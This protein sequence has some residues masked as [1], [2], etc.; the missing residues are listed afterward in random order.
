MTT[1]E[2]NQPSAAAAKTEAE[3]KFEE[4]Q[5]TRREKIKAFRKRLK[6]YHLLA[7]AVVLLII[8]LFIGWH[9]V[10]KKM[11]N[12]VVLDK[13][14]LSYLLY[15]YKGVLLCSHQRSEIRSKITIVV[16]TSPYL[17]QWL[18]LILTRNYSLFTIALIA[19]QHDHGQSR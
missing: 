6:W 3:L 4:Q 2:H 11:M 16:V 9:F 12:I 7:A 17:F 15:A 13:T 14:V 1:N 18:A 10:P 19:T 8:S 5:Q